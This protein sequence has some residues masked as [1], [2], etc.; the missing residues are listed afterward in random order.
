VSEI[1][2]GA[3]GSCSVYQIVCSPF[4]N[5]LSARE[6]RVIKGD[7]LSH[8]REDLLLLAKLAAVD[9]PS[10]TWRPTST[11]DVREYAGRARARWPR[12][13]RDDLAKPARGRGR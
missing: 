11:S 2:L 9:P 8:R 3:N 7:R 4:R 1:D 5:P 6:R 10:A 13:D 12:G